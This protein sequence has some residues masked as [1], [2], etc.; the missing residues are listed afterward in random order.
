MTPYYRIVQYAQSLLRISLVFAI[1]TNLSGCAAAI[2]GIKMAGSV[3]GMGGAY[4]SYKAS[5]QPAVEAN[6]IAP[7]CV[8][9]EYVR[10]S[11]PSRLSLTADEAKVIRQN[12]KLY[13]EL[14][15][16]ATIP[17]KLACP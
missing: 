13:G 9:Y 12:N 11:C 14:C 5:K 1:Y 15:P 10:V 3:A 16:N 6:V 4:Y 2:E 8:F 17:E 7:E